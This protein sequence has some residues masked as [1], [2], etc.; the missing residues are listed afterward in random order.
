VY[1]LKYIGPFLRINTLNKSNIEKQ[2]FH[3]SKETLKYLV[4]QSKCGITLPIKELKIKN[5]PNIDINTISSFSPLLCIYKKANPKLLSVE[6]ML[7]LE[8]D[9]FKKEILISSNA[10]MTL[11][12]IELSIYYKKFKDINRE[13]YTL[14]ILYQN[15]A[16]K[17]LDFY[18]AQ[19]RNE[20]GVFVD[21]KYATDSA[22]EDI[23]LEE[24]NKKFKFSDQAFLMCAFYKYSCIDE[25]KSGEGYRNFSLD[26][27][28]MLLDFKDNLYDISFEELCKLSLA[29]NTFY[30][31]SNL[32][33][34][35]SLLIDISEY[36]METQRNN[37]LLKLE[38]KLE[39]HCLLSINSILLYNST[40][41]LIFKEFAK[42][43][44]DRLLEL[45]NPELGI[46]VKNLEK[47]ETSYSSSEIVFYLISI[48]LYSNMNDT[49]SDNNL[50][51][52]DIFKRQLVESGIILSWP[53]VPAIDDM[54]RYKDDSLDSE[55]LLQDQNF[56]LATIATPENAEVASI[57]IKYVT[58]NRKKEIFTQ[59]KLTF[60]TADNMLIFFLMLRLFSGKNDKVN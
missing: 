22:K 54:E 46:F 7:S 14:G 58:Y 31:Y 5:T 12:I 59:S 16:K 3:L 23:N 1:V 41:I 42:E 8:E 39:S 18:A 26:I 21:K 43:I 17:Q 49:S 11:S 6:N 25:S 10:L 20:E 44:N 35:K 2:L 48:L 53:D 51:I 55:D 32:D 19:L 40:N 4:L 60:D 33:Q 37:L 13:K 9:S 56:K 34:A 29:L 52:I 47:K 15:L 30:K 50:I 45:Y 57:F 27:L 24:K 36:L 28:K 38:S